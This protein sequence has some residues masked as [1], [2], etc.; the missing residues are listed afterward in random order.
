M[1]FRQ[2]GQV[3]QDARK[4]HGLTQEQLADMTGLT[5]NTVSRIERGLLVPSLPTL[6]SLCNALSLAADAVLAAYV[7]AA[8]P[9]RWSALADRMNALPPEKCDKAETLLRCIIDTL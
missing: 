5:S 2:G 7:D 3:I 1:D 6:I 8:A 4:A 9:V